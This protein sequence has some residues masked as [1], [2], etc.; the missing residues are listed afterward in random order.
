MG[1]GNQLR[2]IDSGFGVVASFAELKNTPIVIGESD[3]DGCAA[4][5]AAEYPQYGYR[6]GI[7][8]ASYAAASFA[9]KHELAEKHG[10]NFEGALTWAFEFEDQ[11]YFSGFRTLATNGIDKPVLNVF[12]MMSKMGGQRVTVQ[13]DGAVE[14]A[15]IM[16]DGVRIKP[17][18]AGIASLQGKRASIMLWH[19]HDD[20]LPGPAAD[21]AL[22]VSGLSGDQVSVTEFRI[23]QTNS[24]AFAA[25]Q[26]MGSPPNPSAE[27]Y[28]QLE[29]AGKL[30]MPHE[31]QPVNVSAGKASLKVNLPRQ[32]VVLLVLE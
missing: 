1:I 3:P 8:Y 24:N 28:A 9:R 10:V 30:A 4:C 14:L 16:R 22:D 25:W 2:D 15:Q 26:K 23:D 21:V 19:Y 11:P 6:N 12:R 18:V 32:A 29:K 20:D 31:A 27:Q 5:R 7:Q 17:D 13:S